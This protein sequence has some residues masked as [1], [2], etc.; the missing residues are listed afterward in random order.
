MKVY[1]EMKWQWKLALLFLVN[2][3]RVKFAQSTLKKIE[4]WF[5]ISEIFMDV[6]KSNYNI[7]HFRKKKQF[8]SIA[9]ALIAQCNSVHLHNHKGQIF[10]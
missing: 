4:F 1:Y 10:P 7:L 6:N 3:S 2:I 8:R 9:L 5:E